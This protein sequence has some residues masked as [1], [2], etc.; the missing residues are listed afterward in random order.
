MWSHSY[1]PTLRL[2]SLPSESVTT[3]VEVSNVCGRDG[4]H[5]IDS[6]LVVVNLHTA[7]PL[8]HDRV[9]GELEEDAVGYQECFRT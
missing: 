9:G 5:C 8:H 4:T 2:F 3:D 6:K 1:V 7:G